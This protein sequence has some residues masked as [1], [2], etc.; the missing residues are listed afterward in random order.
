MALINN[1]ITDD[2]ESNQDYNEK[3][4]GEVDKVEE[5]RSDNLEDNN[6]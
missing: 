4:E 3:D 1:G 6:P 2:E 5:S